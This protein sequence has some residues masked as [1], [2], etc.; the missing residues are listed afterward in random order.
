MTTP[1]PVVLTLGRQPMSELVASLRQ[2][3]VRFN[4]YAEEMLGE[5]VMEAA[6][7]VMPV[8]VEVHTLVALGWAEGALMDQVLRDVVDQGLFPCPLEAALLLRMAWRHQ[9]VSPRITVASARAVPDV[10]V[11]R[12]FYLRDDAEGCWLRAYVASDDWVFGPEERLALLRVEAR[13]SGT[14]TQHLR[15]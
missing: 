9:P 5:G 4:A 11:P 15:R 3:G 6:P 14:R 8:G 2:S 7:E 10:S 1:E 13:A 12:G